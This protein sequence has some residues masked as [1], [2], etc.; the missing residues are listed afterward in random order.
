MNK[1]RIL[2]LRLTLRFVVLILVIVIGSMVTYEFFK[3]Y[4]NS[5]IVLFLSCS[6]II[7]SILFTVPI[8]KLLGKEIT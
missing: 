4:G 7:L 1:N 2:C 6:V 8:V 3:I 5:F